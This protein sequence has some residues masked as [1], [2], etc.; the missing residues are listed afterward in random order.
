VLFPRTFDYRGLLRRIRRLR[1]NPFQAYGIAVAAVV[2]AT[3]IRS[4]LNEQLA[5]GGPFTAYNLAIIVATF[6]GGFWPGLAAL[7]I[8]VVT[9]WYLFLDPVFSFALPAKQAWMLSMFTFVSAINVIL[10]SVLNRAIDRMLAHEEHQQFLIGE[11]HHRSQNLFSVIQA[12]ASRT[13]MEEESLPQAQETLNSRLAALAHAH[14]LLAETGWTGALLTKIIERVLAGFPKQM[15]ITGCGILLN[16]P[17]AQN[18]ALILHELATNSVKYGALSSAQGRVVITGTIDGTS[19]NTQFRLLWKE[20]GGPSV[21]PPERKG[22]GNTI[23][24]EAARRFAQNVEA[25]YGAEGLTYD[26]RILLSDLQPSPTE[27]LGILNPERRDSPAGR[28]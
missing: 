3:V 18:F 23:L 27:G 7:V 14:A 22:F 19:R 1:N 9:G 15:S 17:M 16:T 25:K 6:F 4:A 21:T 12:I 24:F 10:V 20:C 28:S 26:I 2:I 13:L 5:E 11:L 8:S